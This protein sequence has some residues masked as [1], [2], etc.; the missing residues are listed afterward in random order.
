VIT[1]V[2]KIHTEFL[3]GNFLKNAHLEYREVAGRITLRCIAGVSGI[4]GIESS[5]PAVTVLV[6]NIR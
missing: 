4:T 2:E 3:C 6:I 1:I 5:R